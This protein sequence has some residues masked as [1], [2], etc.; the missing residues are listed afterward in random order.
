MFDYILASDLHMDTGHS[1]VPL[2]TMDWGDGSQPILIAGDLGNGLGNFGFIEKLR[3]K[4]HTVYLTDGNHE[5]YSNRSQKRTLLETEQAFEQLRRHG[6]VVQLAPDLWLIMTNGWYSVDDEA[7]WQGYMN[8]SKWG[9]ISAVDVNCAAYRHAMFL[10]D[11]IAELPDGARAIIMTHT[12]P[13][14][15][16]LDPR[17]DGSPGNS[18]YWNPLMQTVLHLWGDRIAVWHHGHTHAP[19]DVTVGD[20]RILTNPRGYPG[21]VHGWRPLKCQV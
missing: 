16:S 21:E 12:A 1:G 4:G 3:R 10:N 2:R 14:L 15:K 9:A 8:D 17:F 20:V 18:Y 13:S 7:H 5:H 19:V 11:Q 6:S